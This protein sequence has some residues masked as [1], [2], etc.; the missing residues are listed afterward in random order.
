MYLHVW[1]RDGNS[2]RLVNHYVIAL[3]ISCGSCVMELMFRRQKYTFMDLTGGQKE[4]GVAYRIWWKSREETQA[5]GSFL[6]VSS[7]NNFC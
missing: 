7:Q 3:P 6:I 1:E 5:K 2:V 4:P